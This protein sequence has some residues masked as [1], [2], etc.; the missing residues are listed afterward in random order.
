[1]K[2]AV[3]C[4]NANECQ[5]PDKVHIMSEFKLN[6]SI[7]NENSS[8]RERGASVAREYDRVVSTFN[9]VLVF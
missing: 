1:M 4:I 9:K 3:V 8:A 6:S 5:I 7:T 2:I